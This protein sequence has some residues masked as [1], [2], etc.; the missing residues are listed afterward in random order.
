[1]AKIKGKTGAV[2]QR[3]LAGATCL[4]LWAIPQA[5]WANC[6]LSQPD[7]ICDG[8]TGAN[9]TPTI[10]GK[11]SV[12]FRN[13]QTQGGDV[14]L[15]VVGDATNSPNLIIE[16]G[17]SI[18]VT[19]TS[20]A[21][22]RSALFLDGR[23]G[24]GLITANIDGN[25]SSAKLYGLHVMTTAAPVTIRQGT[26]STITGTQAGQG[27]GEAI[28]VQTTGAAPVSVTTNGAVNGGIA[29]V[30]SLS[31]PSG[32]VDIV[33][34]GTIGA[35]PGLAGIA[36]SDGNGARSG[37][38]NITNTGQILTNG[39]G[40]QVF[41]SAS[42]GSANYTITTLG[43]VGASSGGSTTL[44]DYSIIL[45]N[46]GG[47]ATNGNVTVNVVNT[48][49]FGSVNVG[50]ST[51]GTITFRGTGSGTIM[52]NSGGPGRFG[53]YN[54]LEKSP[55]AV[56]VDVTQD[57]IF[58]PQ[59]DP[60][61]AGVANTG[62]AFEVIARGSGSMSVNRTSGGGNITALVG[63]AIS[64]G[65]YNGVGL[66]APL[67]WTFP[68]NLAGATD[69]YRL[70]NNNGAI[71]L[72]LGAGRTVRA[73]SGN[74]IYVFSGYSTGAVRA[75][76]DGTI[77]AGQAGLKV[78][79]TRSNVTVTLGS[80]SS[81]SATTGVDLSTALDTM[82]TIDQP[83]AIGYD[84]PITYSLTPQ[85][86]GLSLQGVLD[87]DNAGT[88]TG[89]TTGARLVSGGTGAAVLT[90]SGTL[91]GGT[92]AV[93]GSTA[94]TAFTLRNT[95][96]LNGGV[97]VTGSSVAA[98]LFANAGTWNV[99]SGNSSF[100][101]GL[102]NTGGTINARNGVAGDNAIVITGNYVGG[103][104]LLLDASTAQS[105][106]D[107]LT[108]GGTATGTTAVTVNRLAQGR[109]AG[110]FLPLITVTGGAAANAF[111]STSFAN[112]G[113]FR[114]SFGKN[115]ANANQ[116]GIIQAFNP[117]LTGLAG[118]HV[119]A[120]TAAA[121]LDDSVLPFVNRRDGDGRQFGLW[122]RA[123]SGS[124]DQG[125]ST[126]IADGTN[127]VAN[128]SN[129]LA[130][131]Y[132]S[133]QGGLDIGWRGLGGGWD[134]HLGVMAGTYGAKG[135]QPATLI[136]LDAPFAGGYFALSGNGLTLEGNVRREWRRFK[137]GNAPLF[138]SAAPTRSDGRAWAGAIAA[139]YR[140]AFGQGFA[141]TPRVALSWSD[142][143]IDTF[144]ID[145]FTRL[146]PGHDSNAVARLGARLGWSGQVGSGLVAE[147]WVG[148]SWVRNLSGREDTV[149]LSADAGG[150]V[151]PYAMNAMGYRE[152]GQYAAGLSLHDPSGRLSGF[153]EGR[154]E[155]GGGVRGEAV[156]AGVRVNF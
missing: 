150:T 31:V 97:N 129:T 4:G 78:N 98:S 94:G 105:R 73:A 137:I 40:I 111:T 3:L 55:G 28:F 130:L 58:R 10:A 123:S 9:T 112:A 146:A 11:R 140:I 41:D 80:G 75:D 67:R 134:L 155:R 49:L 106:A 81:I 83:F 20:V 34:N 2:R 57:I 149:L 120:A 114:E 32:S 16:N 131:D 1:M 51:T 59:F 90:N 117:L 127:L 61:S 96:T 19:A 65:N 15:E 14:G 86:A 91:G 122:I 70:L 37:D 42:S 82:T 56:T 27:L 68:T 148:A 54:G 76:I 87:L 53:V 38:V 103:G 29:V 18:T 5:A 84:G 44:F 128:A 145:A 72:L 74:G 113:V 107:T 50:T 104:T 6:D 22:Q 52:S 119:T 45:S 139:S 109:V 126:V 60:A 47:A 135:T 8:S 64:I 136:D 132:R 143:R 12:Q 156:T 46:G 88:V 77:I 125:L 118:L 7:V 85:I 121:A 13:G 153:V 110:G 152:T 133:L 142:S 151:L 17:S 48:S 93:L 25:L 21:P 36:I 116:F 141:L 43:Q 24:T 35:A 124:L 138:G 154:L 69:A 92:N 101:G 115:P 100:A 108:I 30:N 102:N 62:S 147:P 79:S 66:S 89:T 63:D 95:G 99:G 33:N 71:D 39:F 26:S 144:A 23:N